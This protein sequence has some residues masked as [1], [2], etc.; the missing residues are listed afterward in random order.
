M[1]GQHVFDLNVL[2]KTS[3]IKIH[4]D[5]VT[6]LVQNSKAFAS[7][8]TDHYVIGFSKTNQMETTQI[9]N[10]IWTDL[11]TTSFIIEATSDYSAYFGTPSSLVVDTMY[12]I[13]FNFKNNGKLQIFFGDI[14]N[15]NFDSSVVSDINNYQSNPTIICSGML[16]NANELGNFIKYESSKIYCICQTSCPKEYEC[17]SIVDSINKFIKKGYI[18]TKGDYEIDFSQLQSESLDIGLAA[19]GSKITVKQSQKMAVSKGEGSTNI[20]SIKFFNKASSS[21]KTLQY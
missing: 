19:K 10:F 12:S 6:I 13:K 1:S 15:M 3:E 4:V 2:P 7:G 21:L 11:S 16:S 5:D 9:K 17:D 8:K 14:R 20:N 18:L